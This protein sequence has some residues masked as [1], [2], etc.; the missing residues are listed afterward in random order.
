MR[1]RQKGEAQGEASRK[2]RE[3]WIKGCRRVTGKK[4]LRKE[5]GRGNTVEY[6]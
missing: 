3:R 4:G 1:G 6:I 2:N 5:A